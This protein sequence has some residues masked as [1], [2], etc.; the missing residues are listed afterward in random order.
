MR[1]ASSSCWGG[2]LGPA[3]AAQREVGAEALGLALEGGIQALEMVGSA[4]GQ[5]YVDDHGAGKRRGQPRTDAQC[6]G[7]RQHLATLEVGHPSTV[8]EHPVHGAQA[9]AS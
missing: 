6:A 8:I 9:H 5:Q 3:L 4:V 7:H 1:K 2:V